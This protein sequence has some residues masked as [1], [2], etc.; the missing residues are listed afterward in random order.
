VEGGCKGKG[1]G[2]PRVGKRGGWR[3]RKGKNRGATTRVLLEKETTPQ[4]SLDF[5]SNGPQ[6]FPHIHAP[7]INLWQHFFGI[8]HHK[9]PNFTKEKGKVPMA[10][11]SHSFHD[12]KNHAFIY[13][14]DKNA[15]NAHH[16][17]CNDRL[18]L[19]MRHDAAFT[20]AL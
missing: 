6:L 8:L 10:S 3:P 1:E 2:Q 5:A 15:K 20:P 12:K 14:H 17:A 4:L 7:N 18:I 9:A 13:T 11:S 16:D 19:P